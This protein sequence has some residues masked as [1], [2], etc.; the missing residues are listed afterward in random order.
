MHVFL[1]LW[2]V[3]LDSA[4]MN[5]EYNARAAGLLASRLGGEESAWR[6]AYDSAWE[7]YLLDLAGAEEK[8]GDWLA[9]ADRLD[10]SLIEDTFKAVNVDWRPPD[11]LSFARDLENQVASSVAVA[12]PEVRGVVES[13]HKA[14]HDVHVATQAGEWNARG[15]LQGSGLIDL[16]DR[17]FSGSSQRTFKSDPAYWIEIPKTVQVTGLK[18]LLVDDRHEYLKAAHSA[19]F[20]AVLLE[21]GE[22]RSGRKPPGFIAKTIFNLSELPSFI[23]SLEQKRMRGRIRK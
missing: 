17:I 15:A 8:A 22:K 14:R 4:K 1:D 5:E 16:M 9:V 18:P 2:G 23:D 3:L 12:Y 20:I 10:S 7:A 11:L 19:G 21:R 6:E 13:L